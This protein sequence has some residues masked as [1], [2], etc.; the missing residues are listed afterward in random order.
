MT[1]KKT[2]AFLGLGMMGGA[3]S[4]NLLKAGYAVRGYDPSAEA[5][6]R[7]RKNGV[8]ILAS[9][10][11]AVTGAGVVC[12]SVPGP[13]D[14]REL[15]LGERGVLAAAAEGTVCFDLSTITPEA[16]CE[17]AEEARR[18][19]VAFLD[20]PVAGTAT[21]A[22]VADLAVMV[23]GDE[24]ALAKHRDV[25]EAIS[26]SITHF[27]PNGSGLRMKLVGNH[28]VSA[29]VCLLAEALTLGRRAGLGLEQMTAYLLQ[30]PVVETI[31]VKV[32]AMARK[33]YAPAFKLDLMAKDLRL[34]ALL[35]ESAKAP[36]P[37]SAQA[38]QIFTAA[39][40]LGRGED[41]QIAVFEAYQR[42]AGA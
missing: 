29:Q 18:R 24:E 31:K 14:V 19:G 36:I 26:R 34:I 42:M 28:M 41:D 27:G 8:Q 5:C 33:D 40:A 3:M 2:V 23:G 16:S 9:P 20:T 32:Q 25:L 35:A 4:N 30:S 13:D 37:I 12:S 17:V 39:Q 11:E 38:K 10:A 6:A 22:V 15:Y 1:E 7:A 21:R